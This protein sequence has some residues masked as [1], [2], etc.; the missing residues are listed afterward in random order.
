MLRFVGD[1]DQQKSPPFF[2]AKFPGKFKAKIHKSF[3]DSGQEWRTITRSIA[4]HE[5]ML[6]FVSLWFHD[7]KFRQ[8]EACSSTYN[9]EVHSWQPV[10]C[11]WFR[12]SF[13]TPGMEDQC[14]M[15]MHWQRW[16]FMIRQE[17][18]RQLCG[19]LRARNSDLSLRAAHLQNEISPPPPKKKTLKR[20]E[21]W[22]EKREKGSEKW[23]ETCPKVFKPLSRRLKI[24]HQ[25]FS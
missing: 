4:P 17:W 13:V 25:H 12:C 19:P 11:V 20:Y 16:S 21:K 1:G 9:I 6:T 10:F 23:S 8:K 7:T 14:A 3:V 18:N 15:P 24:S 22:F 2:A 5:Q